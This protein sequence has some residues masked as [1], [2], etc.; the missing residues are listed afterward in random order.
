MDNLFKADW[1]EITVIGF[2]FA[3][4]F[5]L[6]N[7]LVRVAWKLLWDGMQRGWTLIKPD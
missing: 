1:Y 2:F 3:A 6:G 4:G 5:Y 7:E